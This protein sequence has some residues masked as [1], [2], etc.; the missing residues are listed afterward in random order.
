[1]G[2]I[3]STDHLP[4]VRIFNPTN[5]L[6]LAANTSITI[7]LSVNNLDTG[8]A[9]N[10]AENYLSA[11]QQLNSTGNVLGNYYVVVE[12]LDALNSTTPADI[13]DFVFASVITAAASSGTIESTITNGLL[14]G[15]YRVTVNT[16]AA[17]HQPVL[18]PISQHGS[19]NDAA[20]V[21]F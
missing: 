7:S 10:P 20:Y 2:Q 8:A 1:M 16:H 11:P 19:L 6:T 14:E 4:S 18:V 9:V 3:P 17:N 5:G 21:R 12:E 13:R 15:F